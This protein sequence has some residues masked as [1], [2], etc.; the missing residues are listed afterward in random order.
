MI[1]NDKNLP[2]TKGDLEKME[3]NFETKFATKNDLEKFVTKEIF[4]SEIEPIK[5]TITRLEKAVGNNTIEILNI[6]TDIRDIKETMATKDDI[7]RIMNAIDA[8]AGEAKDYRR[9]DADRGHILMEHHDKL[10]NH[11][12]RVTA[13]EAKK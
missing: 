3:A 9:K 11:E 4:K 2:A 7:N 10:E 6:K 12:S 8:F 13:L 5:K 1:S